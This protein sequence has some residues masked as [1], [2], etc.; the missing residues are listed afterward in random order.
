MDPIYLGKTIEERYKNYLK[1]TFFFKD[2][3]LRRSFEEALNTG[4]LCKGP[5]LEAT[6]PFR[7]GQT[8]RTLFPSLLGTQPDEEFL[9]AVHGDRSL[10][11]HQEEA[12]SK[13]WAG[14]NIVVATGTGSGKTE[15]FLYPILLYLYQEFLAGT[16]GP[17]VRALILYP[18]NALANDQ[19]DR[20]GQICRR[21]KQRHSPF[22][23][24]FGQYIGE[25]PEDEND[26]SRHARDLLAERERQGHSIMSN[27]QVIHG[28]LVLRCEMRATPPNILITNYSMLEYLLLRPLDSVLFDRGQARW[29]TFLVLDEA[30]QY[31]G[32]RGIEMGMLIRRLKQRLREGGRREPF[33]C[34]ATS[35][36]LA[37]GEKDRHAVME[38]A[39]SLFDEEFDEDC[40]IMGEVE[41]VSDNP[42]GTLRPDDYRLL[43]EALNDDSRGT[44]TNP[45][46]LKIG[47]ALK[48]P[49]RSDLPPSLLIGEIL[50]RDSRS[51]NLRQLATG[52]IL[53]IRQIAQEIF[54][55]LPEAERVS[56][57]SRLV[58][59]LSRVDDPKSGV[60]LLSPRYHLFLRSLEGAFV[61]YWPEKK[62]Y[63]ERK[64]ADK[65]GAAFEVALC[66][67]CGQH[68][69]VG[70]LQNRRLQEAVRDPCQLNFGVDFFRPTD[71]LEE[72]EGEGADRLLYKLC[73]ICGE[74]S[75]GELLCGHDI[76]LIL[77]KEESPP[78]EERADQ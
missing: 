78:D 21:L 6:P 38:F 16:L 55:E 53:E 74:L 77:Q 50:C 71:N 29:W 14:K 68:Y 35:A 62:V 40:L 65:E 44:P 45:N 32:S 2:T 12:I 5:Y 72:A 43:A 36:T 47:Q 37:G 7:K 63:L 26:I 67:E 59:L 69:F 11:H 24:T 9:D 4:H 58:D 66:K 28:E 1:T 56:A 18:M 60:P 20:L 22:T 73:L 64:A 3:L 51:S 27:G 42:H 23:F 17:G 15:S 57:L 8:P 10:Y 61:S 70:R 31:R 76:F 46:L 54:P 52:N 34:I 30:H 13:V 75:Q 48:V 25:T 49:V 33:R 19:R 39:A 41:P